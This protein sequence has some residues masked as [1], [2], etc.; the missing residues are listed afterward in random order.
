MQSHDA[1][2]VD[3]DNRDNRRIIFSQQTAELGFSWE[4]CKEFEL[5]IAGGKAFGTEF[6]Y[7]FDSRDTDS[8][9]E[10]SDEAY[11]RIAAEMKF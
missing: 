9:V 3:Q 2:R 8:V 1:F 6:E 10:L 4:P 7:G 5:T 11:F